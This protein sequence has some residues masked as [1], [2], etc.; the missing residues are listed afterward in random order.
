[1][2]GKSQSELEIGGRETCFDFGL[3]IQD[4]LFWRGYRYP[5]APKKAKKK[6]KGKR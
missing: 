2:N 3:T 5:R 1:M 6:K 4:F